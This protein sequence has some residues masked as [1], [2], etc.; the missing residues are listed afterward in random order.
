[1]TPVSVPAT[2]AL[3][4]S[5]AKP[6]YRSLSGRGASSR[7]SS[8]G[9]LYIRVH[10]CLRQSLECRGWIKNSSRLLKKSL[11]ATKM[12][13]TNSYKSLILHSTTPDWWRILAPENHFSAAY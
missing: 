6:T 13:L 8:E 3:G 11:E 1:M 4:I 12:A 5:G 9:E 2:S 7:R 10:I